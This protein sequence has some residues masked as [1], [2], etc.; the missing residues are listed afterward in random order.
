MTIGDTMRTYGWEG[1]GDMTCADYIA[2]SKETMPDLAGNDVYVEI[3]SGYGK[4]V[5]VSGRDMTQLDGV[6]EALSLVGKRNNNKTLTFE[7]IRDKVKT[8]ERKR[9]EDM[10]ATGAQE[11][12]NKLFAEALGGGVD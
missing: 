12:L 5:D 9:D 11:I 6:D 7:E 4:T 2:F 3:P 1:V 8:F 10:T